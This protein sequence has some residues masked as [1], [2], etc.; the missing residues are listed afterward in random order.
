MMIYIVTT[1][2]GDIVKVFGN[3]LDVSYYIETK[4]N[5]IKEQ[6][7]KYERCRNCHKD[8]R[9]Y[10]HC[11]TSDCRGGCENYQKEPDDVEVYWDVYNIE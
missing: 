11:Y 1:N 9:W 3:E 5:E 6:Y 10:K 7:S 4:N 8:T 2:Y